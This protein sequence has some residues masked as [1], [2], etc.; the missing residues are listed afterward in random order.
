MGVRVVRLQD[1]IKKWKEF[2]SNITD[3]VTI[4]NGMRGQL[5]IDV[6]INEIIV[7]VQKLE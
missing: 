6:V 2:L 4:I 1:V 3:V 7:Q 5:H